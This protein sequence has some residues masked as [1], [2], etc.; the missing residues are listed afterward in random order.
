[1]FT[2]ITRTLNIGYIK[3]GIG[4]D[5]LYVLDSDDKVLNAVEYNLLRFSSNTYSL[6]DIRFVTLHLPNGTFF[7]IP[8]KEESFITELSTK[9]LKTWSN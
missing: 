7:Q 6:S 8:P 3:L 2:L 9:M 5:K 1:M 4:E